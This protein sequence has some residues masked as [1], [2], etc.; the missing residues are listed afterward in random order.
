MDMFGEM[1]TAIFLH[2]GSER[3]VNVL[4]A[5][6]CVRM[7]TLG[8]ARA[9]G[10]EDQIGSLEPGKQADFI[11]IDM[12]Y[13]HFTPVHDPYS[14]LVYGANQEDVFFTMVAGRPLYTRKVLLTLDDEKIT[15]DALDAK[16]ETLA[17]APYCRHGRDIRFS[18]ECNV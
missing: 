12:E 15:A 6:E 13:S 3:D 14:A 4:S 2:R 5:A 16:G 17:L 1:R 9:L 11:A 18:A 10:M 8:G 7:A